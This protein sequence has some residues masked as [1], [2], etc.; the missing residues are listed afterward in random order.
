MGNHYVCTKDKEHDISTLSQE[1][2]LSILKH[3]EMPLHY[4]SEQKIYDMFYYLMFRNQLQE[5]RI[6]NLLIIG[7][8]DFAQS[9]VIHSFTTKH[10]DY[11]ME[12]ESGMSYVVKP[13]IFVSISPDD[14]ND[15]DVKHLYTSILNAFHIPFNRDDSVSKLRKQMFY[16][17]RETN[18]H[19]IIINNI[20]HFLQ[21]TQKQQK[22][23]VD[24]LKNI[25]DELMIPLVCAGTPSS[26]S[27]FT[28]NK[29]FQSSFE[30]MRTK[31]WSFDDFLDVLQS[32]E[33]SLPLQKASNLTEE[34]KAI[35]LYNI[36]EGDLTILHSF[37]LD[38]ATFAINN[39]IEEISV[40]I[41]DKFRCLKAEKE[42]EEMNECNLAMN[43]CYSE[44]DDIPF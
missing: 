24:S 26:V 14:I 2:R 23:V 8:F 37:L 39:D 30:E 40:E 28:S 12:D 5:S 15:M 43:E 16:L 3:I 36:S 31:E 6:K 1:D 44:I 34:E 22:A 29:P 32:I 9:S 10:C 13:V 25:R 35:S 18:V 4:P 11:G 19:L 33:D 42:I 21:G 38:C 7:D 41:I 27:L 20:H 17:C